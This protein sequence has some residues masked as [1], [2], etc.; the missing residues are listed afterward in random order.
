VSMVGCFLVMSGVV[1][2]GRFSVV[3]RDMCGVF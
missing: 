2:L 3:P 1:M